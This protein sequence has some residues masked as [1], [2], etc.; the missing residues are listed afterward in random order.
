MLDKKLLWIIGIIILAVFIFNQSQNPLK[1]QSIADI[2]SAIVTRTLSSSTILINQQ[3][4][5]TYVTS[6][7]GIGSW[8]VLISDA[9]SGGCTPATYTSGKISDEPDLVKTY[10]APST[11]ATCTFTGTYQYSGNIIGTDTPIQGTTIINIV[12]CNSLRGTATSSISLW[13]VTPTAGNKQLAL[14]AIQNWA[15]Y[16]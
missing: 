2:S 9:V 15:T 16:C 4:T 1:T 11:P 12:D 5:A 6:G 3:F 10:T 7:Y 14:T 13:A 8:G